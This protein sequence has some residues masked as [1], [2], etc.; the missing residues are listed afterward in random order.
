MSAGIDILLWILAVLASVLASAITTAV[1]CKASDVVNK[2]GRD[3]GVNASRGGKFMALTWVAT[4]LCFL[5][6]FV[7]VFECLRGSR[8]ANRESYVRG[9]GGK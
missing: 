1:A 4:G 6:V 2:H 8:R 5:N 9:I 3:I 7:W